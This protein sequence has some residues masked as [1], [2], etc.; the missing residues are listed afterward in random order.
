M[1]LTYC[2]HI[3]NSLYSRRGGAGA[4][5]QSES[6]FVADKYNMNHKERGIAIIFN[7]VNFHKRTQMSTRTGSD[8]DS[9]NMY[10][11]LSTMGFA[12]IR[13]YDDLSVA[14]MKQQ[15]NAG[16]I[17]LNNYRL[18]IDMNMSYVF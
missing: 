12:E 4:V 11:L 14:N 8:V 2:L 3:P 7:N 9:Q 15:I 13:T 18:I 16:E 10:E 5:P 17:S 6:D 1:S